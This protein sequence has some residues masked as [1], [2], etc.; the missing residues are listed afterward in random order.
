[1]NF[2]PFPKSRALI[3]AA[4]EEETFEAFEVKRPPIDRRKEKEFMAQRPAKELPCIVPG[5]A[6][7]FRPSTEYKD[8]L[9]HWNREHAK[10]GKS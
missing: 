3:A 4:I 8:F 6:K 5:C 10:G 7:H 2:E 1:M 9:V